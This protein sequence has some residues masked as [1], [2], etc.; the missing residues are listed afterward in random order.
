MSLIRIWASAVGG[1]REEPEAPVSLEERRE[2][3]L[4]EAI[5]RGEPDAFRELVARYQHRVYG[6]VLRILG[7]EAEA[8][9]VAQEV[10]VSIHKHI[11]GW[12]GEAKL[13]TWIY[14]VATN[15]A[16][17][18][19]K[20]NARRRRK[21]HRSW[22]EA[23]DG[24]RGAGAPTHIGV[25]RPDRRAQANELERIVRDGLAALSE[26]HRT[27]V[28]LRD[29]EALSY[30]EIVEVTGLTEGTVKSRLFRARAGLKAYVASRYEDGYV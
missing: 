1:A 25:A 26:E 27:I 3:R 2:R 14:C 29:I 30:A 15:H 19:L 4:V 13:S 28:V 8:E 16:R 9:D 24:G 12:R 21:S 18:R 7:D 11:G 22:D 23:L 5:G 10:F 17:N 6:L 20:Y